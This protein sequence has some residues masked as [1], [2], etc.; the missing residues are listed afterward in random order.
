MNV[1]F[2]GEGTLG[3]GLWNTTTA[4]LS[5][6]DASYVGWKSAGV[7][8]LNSASLTTATGTSASIAAQATEYDTRDHILN[9]AV[10]IT[11]GA[12]SGF[13]DVATPWDTSS[14]ATAWSAP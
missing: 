9:R 5:I 7:S 1:A 3:T 2:S 14:L 12:P 6:G 4:P 13:Q 8:G 10:T 11:S